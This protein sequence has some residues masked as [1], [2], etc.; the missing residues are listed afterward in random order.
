MRAAV[1]ALACAGLWAAAAADSDAQGAECSPACESQFTEC[2]DDWYDCDH[3]AAT[4]ESPTC[5][6]ELQ[7]C[8]CDCAWSP[9]M[10]KLCPAAAPPGTSCTSDCEDEL[11]RWLQLGNGRTCGEFRRRIS[12][13]DCDPV[14][15]AECACGCKWTASM[16]ERCS[17]PAPTQSSDDGT[18][19]TPI[20]IGIA[21]GV[22]VVLGCLL[23]DAVHRRRSNPNRHMTGPPLLQHDSQS[24]A[25][26]LSPNGRLSPAEELRSVNPADLTFSSAAAE[27]ARPS[28]RQMSRHSVASDITIPSPAALPQHPPQAASGLTPPRRQVSQASLDAAEGQLRS[29]RA[30][31]APGGSGL[32]AAT[33]VAA[34]SEQGSEFGDSPLSRYEVLD[35]IGSGSFGVVYKV[36]RKRDSRQFALKYIACHTMELRTLA[37]REFGVLSSLRHRAVIQVVETLIWLPEQPAGSPRGAMHMPIGFDPLRDPARGELG[38]CVCLVL[39]FYDEGDLGSFIEEC[40]ADGTRLKQSQ[41]LSFVDQI[42]QGL[43]YLHSREP[44]IVHRDLKPNNV[45]LADNKK[46]AVLSDFGLSREQQG[47]ACKSV[48]GTLPYLAPEVFRRRYGPPMD[49]WGLGCMLHELVTLRSGEDRLQYFVEAKSDEFVDRIK[50]DVADA[51][52]FEQ[53]GDILESMLTVSPDDR[54]TAQEVLVAARIAMSKAERLEARESPVPP[55]AV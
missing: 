22:L 12:L 35:R 30:A 20:V 5:N 52:Y 31:S 41:L 38:A 40:A 27:Y 6:D 50:K 2:A 51:G 1:A 24:P 8:V 55:I 21:A 43:Q 7:D 11:G 10:D 19:L 28:S 37:L 33:T 44:P 42:A 14:L 3:C 46:R 47:S 18:D 16:E 53:L 36:K 54:A 26:R 34:P 23:A 45:L 17:T 49:V 9:G 13:A 39:P 48:V 15:Y 32:V 25:G 29:P 4:I